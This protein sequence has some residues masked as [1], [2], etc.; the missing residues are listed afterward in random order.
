M[1]RFE[2]YFFGLICFVSEADEIATAELV[3]APKHTAYIYSPDINGGIPKQLTQNV[4]IALSAGPVRAHKQFTKDVPHL[5]VHTIRS[6]GDTV[7]IRKEKDRDPYVTSRL[8]LPAGDLFVTDF[9]PHKGFFLGSDTAS[10]EFNTPRITVL[11]ADTSES[12]VRIFHGEE[13][14]AM[15]PPTSYVVLLNVSDH[16]KEDHDHPHQAKMS[17]FRYF[18]YLTDADAIDDLL[19]GKEAK[20]ESGEDSTHG[21]EVTSKVTHKHSEQLVDVHVAMVTATQVDCSSSQWP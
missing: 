11:Q 9:Y 1:A 21:K 17:H 8:R 16:T 6:D 10:A 13:E 2:I 14:L 18:R 4:A 3:K 19:E 15:L 5:K 7:H 20:D 12:F